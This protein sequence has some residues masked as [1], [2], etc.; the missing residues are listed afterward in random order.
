MSTFSHLSL[1]LANAEQ[2]LESRKRSFQDWGR[3]N[4]LEEYLER[5]EITERREVAWDGRY[6]TW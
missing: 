2:T 3:G 5:D 1:Y 6:V 4:T